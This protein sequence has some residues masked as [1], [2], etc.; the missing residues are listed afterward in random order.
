MARQAGHNREQRRESAG[1]AAAAAASAQSGRF[2]HR[3]S[4][5]E[6]GRAGGRG[7][8]AAEARG[9]AGGVT[10]ARRAAW[11]R[12]G[13]SAAAPC[14]PCC[15]AVVLI[16]T[17]GP[18]WRRQRPSQGLALP[19]EHLW[20]DRVAGRRRGRDGAFQATSPACASTRARRWGTMMNAE[21]SGSR[22]SLCPRGPA[23][24]LPVRAG[25]APRNPGKRS[26]EWAGSRCRAQRPIRAPES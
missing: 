23:P 11:A 13:P 5:P 24:T 18:L 20:G 4:R 10:S 14:A 8:R 15:L 6:R 16:R 1:A 25:F 7:Q 26:E 19:W 17:P 2:P 21:S 9:G 3:A 22:R 12:A